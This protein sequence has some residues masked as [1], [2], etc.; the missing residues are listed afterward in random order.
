MADARRRK[1]RDGHPVMM[2]DPS[3][4]RDVRQYFKNFVHFVRL[5]LDIRKYLFGLI[6]TFIPGSTGR[7]VKIIKA[8]EF[9]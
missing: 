7:Q 2:R 1:P 9:S 3:G 8:K 6:K 4:L 5:C